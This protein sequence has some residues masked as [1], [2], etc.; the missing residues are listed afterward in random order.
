MGQLIISQ[1]WTTAS[2]QGYGHEP[3]WRITP[4]FEKKKTWK[5]WGQTVSGPR[6]ETGNFRPKKVPVQNVYQQ[7]Y[8]LLGRSKFKFLVAKYHV[9]DINVPLW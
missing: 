7:K 3:I 4:A 1:Y 2:T 9:A 6:F 5:Q 8:E